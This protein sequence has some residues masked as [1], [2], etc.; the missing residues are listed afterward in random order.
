LGQFIRELNEAFPSLDLTASD[1]TLIHRGLVPAVDR[2]GVIMLDGNDRVIDHA[3]SSQPIAGLL[4]VAATK[5]TTARWLAEHTVDLA[6]KKLNQPAV[7][8]RT[9]ITHLLG[10]GLGDTAQAVAVARREY[11]A[12]LPSRTIPHLVAA[13]GSRY[14]DVALLAASREE[15]RSLLSHDSPVVGGQLIHAA[16]QE[17]AVTLADAVVRRTPLGALGLPGDAVLSRAAAL[18]ATEYRWDDERRLR[19][20]AAVR[21]FYT[22]RGQLVR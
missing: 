17:M 15:W 3:R 21:D 9:A 8:C 1:V 14:G 16:R 7:A 18:M 13:Y 2:G 5:Y 6:L 12:Q 20:I 19:E 22:L 10:G 11:E 4:T